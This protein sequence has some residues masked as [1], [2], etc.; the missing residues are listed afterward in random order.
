MQNAYPLATNLALA[1][2]QV[3]HFFPQ[4][5]YL[6]LDLTYGNSEIDIKIQGLLFHTSEQ[7]GGLRQ[8]VSFNCLLYA[9]HV[10]VCVSDRDMHR[11]ER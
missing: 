9:V 11:G 3:F 10:Y 6:F 1:F 7:V 8:S 2:L 5:I 4:F